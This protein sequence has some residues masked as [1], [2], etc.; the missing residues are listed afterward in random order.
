M[1][2]TFRWLGPDDPVPL[3]HIAQIPGV[4][5]AVAALYDLPPGRPWPADAIDELKQAIERVGL[6]FDIVESLPVHEDIKL[7]RPTRDEL[8]DVYADNLAR[9]GD[10]GVSVVVYNFMPLFDWFRTDLA[11]AMAD[12]STTLAFDEA[13]LDAGADPWAADWPAY[14]PLDEPAADL[15]TAYRGLDENALRANLAYFLE[16]VVPA[17]EAAGVVLALHPDDPPWPIFGIPRV[18]KDRDDLA[19]VLAAVDRLANGLTLCVGSLGANPT[20]DPPAL[21][22]EFAGRIHFVHGRNLR[23]TG[24]RTFHEVAHPPEY[25]DVDLVA[26]LGALHD[27]GYRGPIRSDHGR[28][29]WGETGSPGYGLYDRALGAAFL[30]GVWHGLTAGE[31]RR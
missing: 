13:A 30:N 24:H 9:L 14:F 23:H 3:Q 19:F 20:N 22:R 29:I 31:R 4:R 26:V 18:V 27:T 25:G 11:M 7:G 21:V 6:A 10:A 8:L 1:Y 28:M 2:V 12:G 16:R 15:A 17:A 5:S